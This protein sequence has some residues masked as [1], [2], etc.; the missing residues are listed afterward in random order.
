MKNVIILQIFLGFFTICI[1]N[2]AKVSSHKHS[3][4]KERLEDGAFS[5]RDH[6]HYDNEGLQT[7]LLINVKLINETRFQN[8]IVNLTM[9]QL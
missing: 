6:M 8:I 4:G 5:P 1:L 9:K 2:L 3:F 7:I